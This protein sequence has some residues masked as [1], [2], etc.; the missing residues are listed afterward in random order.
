MN[1][2]A[3]VFPKARALEIAR[4]QSQDRLYHPP[5][6]DAMQAWVEIVMLNLFPLGHVHRTLEDRIG[7]KV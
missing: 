3:P 5:N 4:K 1:S 2:S 6:L 7:T